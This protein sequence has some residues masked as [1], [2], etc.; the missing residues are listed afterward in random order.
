MS[1]NNQE[2]QVEQL[3]KSQSS[4]TG[5]KLPHYEQGQPEVTILKIT[6][7][8]G[9]KL[10]LHKHSVI[11]AGVLLKGKLTVVSDEGKTLHM[12]AGDPIVELVN[13]WHY[14]INEGKEP[15]E[16]IVFYAGVEGVPIT[17]KKSKN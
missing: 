5:D 13:K 11:N 4:W 9:T 10:P 3:A 1:K 8:A 6:I 2:T 14:G 15:A 16:I 17:T 12:K 7:P